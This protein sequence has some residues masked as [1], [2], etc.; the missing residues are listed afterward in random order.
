MLLLIVWTSN[1]VSQQ[2][3]LKEMVLNKQILKDNKGN[4]IGVF[5]PMDEYEKILEVLEDIEDIKL[6][7]KAKEEDDG[8]RI[9]LEDYLHDRNLK[10]E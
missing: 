4:N 3:T 7:D 2:F 8:V 10:N 9:S 1:F 5:L 6:Y